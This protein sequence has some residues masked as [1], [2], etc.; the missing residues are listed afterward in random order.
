M[1]QKEFVNKLQAKPGETNYRPI[2]VISQYCFTIENLLDVNRTSFWPQPQIDSQLV[3][4]TPNKHNDMAI[5]TLNNLNYIF[6]RR[7]KKASSVAKILGSDWSSNCNW[8]NK[9]IYQLPPRDLVHFAESMIGTVIKG[10][11]KKVKKYQKVMT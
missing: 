10:R 8:D 3:R 7:N 9:R 5:Q 11:N 4:L 6:S 1:L 2:S